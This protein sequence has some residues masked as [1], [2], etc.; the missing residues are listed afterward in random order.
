MFEMQQ[1][2]PTKGDWASS[3]KELVKVYDLQLNMEE[4]KKT[5]QSVFKNLVKGKVEKFA[6]KTLIEK[7]Q[8]GQKGRL[9]QYERLELADYLLP[10]CEISVEERRE[11]FSVRTEMDD[12]PCNFGNVT[13]CDMG[14]KEVLNSE[15]L[16]TCFE[17]NKEETTFKFENILK[18]T[19]KQKVLIIKKIQENKEKKKTLTNS[20]IQQL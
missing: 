14:C 8:K 7:Q 16:L 10:E 2:H 12:F 1:K 13:N 3:V 5:K 6:F 11:I 19:M 18:G 15:H 9:L 17:I 20:G 4:I